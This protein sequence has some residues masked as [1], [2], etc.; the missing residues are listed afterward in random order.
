MSSTTK[1]ETTSSRPPTPRLL[2]QPARAPGTLFDGGWWPRSADP[3]A[4]L[5]SLIMALQGPGPPGDH[6]PVTHVLL[7]AS[8]WD[9]RPRRLRIEG[10]EGLTDTRVVRL[11]WFEALP[12]GR[13]IAIYADGHG[14]DLLTVPPRTGRNTAWTAMEQA[15][16][17]PE[18]PASVTTVT[19]PSHRP[20]H[21]G[22]DS[23]PGPHPW[24]T[25]PGCPRREIRRCGRRMTGFQSTPYGH[26]P[27]LGAPRRA[28]GDRAA[29]VE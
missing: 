13:T 5:P 29:P 8:D 14:L 27:A 9:S 17:I 15:I 1:C 2:L 24:D 12:G 18:I 11:S 19:T 6:G 3:V 7:R 20:H 10:T 22:R 4:E 23:R 25:D 16:R 26:G 28:R 21:G